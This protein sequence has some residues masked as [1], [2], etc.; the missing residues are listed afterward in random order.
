[1]LEIPAGMERHFPFFL[2]SETL[3]AKHPIGV[4]FEISVAF[5]N[6]TSRTSAS[7]DFFG[8]DS[9]EDQISIPALIAGTTEIDMN[10]DIRSRAQ[11]KSIQRHL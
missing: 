2:D 10:C 9:R 3:L 8:C 7:F 6:E 5:H 4:A 11:H 1:M